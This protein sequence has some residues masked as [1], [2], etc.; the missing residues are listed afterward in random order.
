MLRSAFSILIAMTLFMTAFTFL[1]S[2]IASCQEP[3]YNPD[4]L[5]CDD[6]YD[7]AVACIQS[8]KMNKNNQ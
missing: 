5:N 8:G 6:V 4:R 3:E 7:Q 2:A 1:I